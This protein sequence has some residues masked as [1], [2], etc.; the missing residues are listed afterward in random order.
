[1]AFPM[2]IFHQHTVTGRD[3][4][5]LAVAHF[6]FNKTVQPHGKHPSRRRVPTRFT[7]AGRDANKPD[8]RRG[9]VV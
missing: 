8:R 2:G 6:K 4:S 5:Y 3:E 7:H 1:M 9:I